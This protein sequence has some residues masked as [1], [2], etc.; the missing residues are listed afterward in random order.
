[1]RR[2]QALIVLAAFLTPGSLVLAASFKW[3]GDGGGH[4][5]WDNCINWSCSGCGFANC[6]PE[7]PND[8]VRIFGDDET[9]TLIEAEEEIEDLELFGTFTFTGGAAQ[10]MREL[11]AESLIISGSGALTGGTLYV[12]GNARL[13]G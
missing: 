4:N 2:K 9:T 3:T 11:K 7:S 5:D 6:F 13:V 12:Q 10:Q 8:D 1:M